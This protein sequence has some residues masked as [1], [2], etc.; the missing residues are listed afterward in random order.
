MQSLIFLNC[1]V[2]NNVVWACLLSGV[3][4]GLNIESN[5]SLFSLYLPFL[6][7]YLSFYRMKSMY[8]GNKE[9]LYEQS[10]L[11]SPHNLFLPLFRLA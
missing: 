10:Q 7:I 8:Q 2:I 5:L 11:K 6:A 3:P 4:S 9:G 1:F